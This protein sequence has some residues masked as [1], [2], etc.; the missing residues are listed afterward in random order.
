MDYC[1]VHLVVAVDRYRCRLVE[2]VGRFPVRPVLA[3]C[4]QA[5]LRLDDAGLPMRLGVLQR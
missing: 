5:D 4:C 2:A 3:D 1:P